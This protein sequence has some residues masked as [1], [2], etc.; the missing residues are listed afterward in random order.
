MLSLTRPPCWLHCLN[1]YTNVSSESSQDRVLLKFCGSDLTNSEETILDLI[2]CPLF[3]YT[4]FVKGFHD[5]LLT[6]L[7][8]I[9]FVPTVDSRWS[10][11]IQDFLLVTHICL[12][13]DK[14]EWF[15]DYLTNLYNGSSSNFSQLF[16]ILTVVIH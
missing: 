14:T 3:V 16:G 4:L 2:K 6:L 7:K 10:N 9:Y 13:K 15:C 11:L 12:W 8:T 5:K 1:E